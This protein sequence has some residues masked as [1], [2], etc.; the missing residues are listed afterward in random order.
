MLRGILAAGTA[1]TLW[2]VFPLYLRL[3][4]QVP[5][6]EILSH[7]VLWSV[8][9]LM[10]LLA[11][12]RQ[13][14]W[15]ESVR[16]RPRIILTFVASALMV[17]TNWVVYIWS[18]NH[19]HI[20]DA[21]LGY[22]ITPLFNVLFGIGLGERL[23]LTQWLAVALA[24]CGV[25]WLTVSAGQLPWIGLVI[26][27]TFSLYGLLRKTAAL[28]AL[29]GLSIETLVLLP[30]ASLFLLLP[31]AGS[32]HAFG[33]DVTLTLLLISAGPVTAIPLLMFAYG[34]RRI[35]LSLMGLLQ[36]I[37]PSIQLLIGVWLFNEPFGG[38]NL[39]GFALIWLGLL[40]YSGDS[41][42][43]GITMSSD[44]LEKKSP[45]E[46]QAKSN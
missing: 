3:M 1:F 38:N 43:R 5:S 24:A 7:R 23:R 31:N 6:L 32:S 37:G 14:D 2:G 26:A 41:L 34:A 35:P 13:W 9:L 29:E 11:I 22:F 40:I 27:V 10:G 33:S 4:K 30:A 21:S 25:I 12:R 19:D 39:I 44:Q 42:A 18:V 45:G 36:Y 20:I 8:V 16:A 46:H 28:G 17:A 15:L